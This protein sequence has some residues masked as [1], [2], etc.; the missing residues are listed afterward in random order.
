MYFAR[1]PNLLRKT[2]RSAVWEIETTKKEIYLTF[3]DGPTPDITSQVLD[4]LDEHSAKATFFCIGKNVS[5][6]TDIYQNI[7]DRGH[8]TGNHTHN[9]LSG[10]ETNVRKYV[11]NVFE[12]GK[13]V[14]S[15]LFRPPYGRIGPRQYRELKDRY[16]IVM[17]SLLSW[18]FD[19]WITPE[20]C[21][22]NIVENAHPGAIAVFHDSLKAADNCLPAL[23][24]TLKQL[25][26]MD[27]QFKALSPP[28]Y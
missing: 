28:D 2:L 12:C 15:K 3:D 24:Q 26:A 18:D 9:H 23:E 22:Q 5:E 19:P 16:T 14:N 27:Y 7:L 17:W 11:K 4:L 1:T 6:H 25:K 20:Q 8:V 13:H 10:W 21:A